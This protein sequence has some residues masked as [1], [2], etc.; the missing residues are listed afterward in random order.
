MIDS[1]DAH[2][3]MTELGASILSALA[4]DGKDVDHLTVHDLAPVDEFHIRGRESTLELAGIA[5]LAPGMS[6]LDVGSGIG[7]S[8]RH[9]ASAHDCNVTGID[10]TK[11]YCD[12]ATM[13][14]GRVGL[15][16][17]TTFT[18]GSALDLPYSDASFDLAWT[19]HV[20][21]N[22]EDKE[23]FYGE[24]AR[25]LAPGGRF[26]FHD[27]L[28]GPG[29]EPHYP[30]PWAGDPS[31]S[32]LIGPEERARGVARVRDLDSGEERDE[33]LPE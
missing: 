17:R 29:G 6:V 10:A 20:Q 27:I 18:H 19:E 1:V 31:I 23:T 16:H 30:V 8:A 3:G 11:E 15:A 33:L 28:S 32:F 7:G 5:G 22:I 21:M 26:A 24:I 12:V 25:V 9:L 4:D 14:S 13:L 2:Y